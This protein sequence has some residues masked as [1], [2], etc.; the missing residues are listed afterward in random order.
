[1]ASVHKESSHT[2]KTYSSTSGKDTS[3]GRSSADDLWDFYLPINRKGRFF[4]DSSVDQERN[5]FDS[6]IKDVLNKWDESDFL[7]EALDDKDFG[8]S[9]NLNRYRKLRSRNM[10]EDNQAVTVTSDNTCH[11]IMLDVHDFMDGEVKVKVVG[12]RELLV[13]GRMDASK[14]RDLIG[15]SNTF[16]RRF[17][18]PDATNMDAITSVMSSDGILTITAPKVVSQTKEDSTIPIK[19]TGTKTN[20]SDYRTSTSTSQAGSDKSTGA[21][22]SKMTETHEEKHKCETRQ[23]SEHKVPIHV[24]STLGNNQSSSQ[25]QSDSINSKAEAKCEYNTA[26]EDKKLRRESEQREHMSSSTSASADTQHSAGKQ[27][28]TET[29]TQSKNSSSTTS[30]EFSKIPFSMHDSV[31]IKRKGHFFDDSFFEDTRLDFENA[32]NDVL[33]RWGEKELLKDAWDDTDL[34]MSNNLRRYRKLR[35][36]DLKEDNQAMTVT[37]DNTCHKIVLDV[38]DFMDGEVKVK[39][40]GERELQVEGR[41]DAAKARD[42]TGVSNTFR[43]RFSLP[44]ATNMDAIT[45]VMS[46]DGVLTITAPRIVT[47]AKEESS[48]IPIK[49]TETKTNVTET[50]KTTSTSQV[51]SD[52]S[53]TSSSAK[54]KDTQEEEGKQNESRQNI[55]EFTQHTEETTAPVKINMTEVQDSSTSQVKESQ[56]SCEQ[57]IS[58]QDTSNNFTL[59]SSQ[60]ISVN[61][62]VEKEAE[63]RKDLMENA[64]NTS[65]QINLVSSSKTSE[66]KQ[67]VAEPGK[68]TPIPIKTR[69][70]FFNDSFFENTWKDY[71]DAVKDIVIKWGDCSTSDDMTCYRRLR[72]RDLRE[73]NQAIKS[74]EDEFNYRFIV[75]VHDFMT[76]GE[77]TVKTLDDR[78]LVVEGCIEKEEEGARS[79][80]RFLR[81]FVLPGNVVLD[82]VS[83]VM[84]SDGVLTITAP[85]RP[86]KLQN[87]STEETARVTAGAHTY[88]ESASVRSKIEE[89]RESSTKAL[90]SSAVD[91]SLVDQTR[92]QAIPVQ[93]N[94]TQEY[95]SRR[96]SELN[97][98]D[99]DQSLDNEQQ[100][101]SG[102]QER[103]NFDDDNTHKLAAE[104]KDCT[105]LEQTEGDAVH[106]RLE[107]ERHTAK[108]DLGE[109]DSETESGR[110]VR[111]EEEVDPVYKNRFLS[112]KTRGPFSG[113]S[114]F[115][116]SRQ[117]FKSA[118]RDVLKKFNG[119]LSSDSDDDIATYR[120]LR[121]RDLKLENQAVHV[122]ED[123]YTQT[124]LLDVYDFL[125]GEVTAKVV[126]GQ[127]LVVEG[128]AKRQQ[129]TCLTTLSFLRRFA[130][131]ERADLKAITAVMSSDGV[132]LIIIPKL[133]KHSKRSAFNKEASSE[134]QRRMDA[135]RGRSLLDRNLRDSSREHSE[136]RSSRSFVSSRLR[137]SPELSSFNKEMSTDSHSR[138]DSN[139]DVGRS[140]EESAEGSEG[141]SS[142]T[143]SSSY[144]SHSAA[145]Q[146]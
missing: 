100:K 21:N 97:A 114:F 123:V 109:D 88:Q 136:G 73:E 90:T 81:H 60:E 76:G 125:G 110:S 29:R 52:N 133:R 58:S 54:L 87:Q 112:I 35:S 10:K 70:L 61:E 18:L 79:T 26:S 53:A 6:A 127:E 83:S 111:Q 22:N 85:K 57:F 142:R 39:V 47:Q 30:E 27:T 118:V 12:E 31:P 13:E 20:I 101:T 7:K 78:E 139:S 124:I 106:R 42:L 15:I 24:S 3:R 68:G 129:G 144:K 4:Q 89:S 135:E 1:M 16:R 105:F 59:G 140:W 84:S 71:Q 43:R 37:S 98:D 137:H 145:H 138:R 126:E 80:K 2:T 64:S 38:R 66:E 146:F 40:V 8:W 103:I 41:M 25:T 75:D 117:N 104:K 36:H 116:E 121:L 65:S 86:S 113:D 49:V 17:S 96:S 92:K 99:W 23:Q 9:S 122:D 50:H 11:K 46:S 143:F 120:D 107:K 93:V 55:N 69:G 63:T 51:G 34:R 14:T 44:D 134:R 74:S 131:P 48:T 94:V 95:Q 72:S 115:L 119:G 45:S 19:V 102:Y 128:R 108:Y 91:E 77:I 5:Q 28:G 132:L 82:S 62:K 141:S 33:K 56:E 130:L 67:S 32:V